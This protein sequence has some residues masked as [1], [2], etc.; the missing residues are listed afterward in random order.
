MGGGHGDVGGGLF[1]AS[2]GKSVW[3]GTA[4]KTLDDEGSR[5]LKKQAK[6]VE[7]T[8]TKAIDKMFKQF[9]A[10]QSSEKR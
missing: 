1:D 2:T 6:K 8:I 5:D 3:R 7:K 10:S 4:K 9:P